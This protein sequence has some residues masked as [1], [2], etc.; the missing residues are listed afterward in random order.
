MKWIVTSENE[1]ENVFLLFLAAALILE[2]VYLCN[3]VN[4]RQVD[5]RT[6]RLQIYAVTYL[7]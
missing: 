7:Y 4:E 3:W 5:R 2:L 1:S 6:K